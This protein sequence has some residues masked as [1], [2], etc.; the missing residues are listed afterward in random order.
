MRSILD[1]FTIPYQTEGEFQY[2]KARHTC[3]FILL[4]AATV[5]AIAA[6]A[7]VSGIYNLSLLVFDLV[8]VT[9]FLSLLF[10]VRSKRLRLTINILLVA[11]YAKLIQCFF[12][13]TDLL[14]YSQAVTMLTV[15]AA[16]HL[17]K[18]QLYISNVIIL[19]LCFVRPF[20]LLMSAQEAMAIDSTFV[21]EVVQATPTL[22][23]LG[24]IILI[25]S[26]I[27]DNEIALTES[28]KN[29]SRIDPLTGLLR[30]G[31]FTQVFQSTI[32]GSEVY[33]IS[34]LDIDHFKSINDAHGHTIGDTV[35]KDFSETIKTV[36][37]K[38]VHVFRWGGEEFIVL[39]PHY[40]LSETDQ[41][42]EHL[43]NKIRAHSFYNNI[44]ITFSAGIAQSDALLT[45][46]QVINAADKAL[47]Q[48]KSSGRNQT[49]VHTIC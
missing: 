26:R 29:I 15:I 2:K 9:I 20:Y 23:F 31:A 49:C 39:L 13:D 17:D 48:A 32:S 10:A 18:K 8:A 40:G 12:L 11:G 24:F 5:F 45:V 42:L 19:G 7:M 46:D 41:V 43:H 35:L 4:I 28:I 27:V 38:D 22:L 36:T 44:Q 6:V 47:Y 1:F 21:Y 16:V 34:I 25:Y 14:F 3:I 30:R 37:P 33:S